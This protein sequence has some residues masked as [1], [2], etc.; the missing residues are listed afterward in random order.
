MRWKHERFKRIRITHSYT[1]F[2]IGDL[3]KRWRKI[4]GEQD[5]RISV[6][7]KEPKS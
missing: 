3:A 1:S 5:P 4:D 6:R 7:Y 2:E